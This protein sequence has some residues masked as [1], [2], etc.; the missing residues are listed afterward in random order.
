MIW[1]DRLIEIMPFSDRS[2][3]SMMRMKYGVVGTLLFHL[4]VILLFMIF[5]VGKTTR[6]DDSWIY[7][8]LK[9]IEELQQL[10]AMK[11]EPKVEEAV[12]ARQARNIAVSQQEDR[13]ERYDDYE[14]YRLSNR[15]VDQIVQGRIK[16]AVK[17]IVEEN[18]LNPDDREIPDL[19]T[20]PLDFFKAQEFEEDQVYEG[21]TNIYYK[22]D[23]RKVSYLHIPVYKC[24]GSGTV[25]IDIRVGQ[26]GKVELATVNGGGTDTRDPC[27]LNAARDAAQRTRFNFSSRAPMLQQGYI[28]YHFVAQ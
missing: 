28:I 25:R 3:H 20:K 11:P 12:A 8:D 17:E 5:N 1:I 21:P 16:D 22:L 2:R 10:E 18:D 15:A 23:D 9:T 26:R 24:A 6:L 13:I 27:F 4:L 7:F 19:E 14:N